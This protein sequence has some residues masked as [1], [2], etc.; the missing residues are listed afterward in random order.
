M[1]A[2][3]MVLPHES[4]D[5]TLT[6]INTSEPYCSE[7]YARTTTEE[8]RVRIRHSKTKATATKP[9]VDR[10]N[11]EVTQIVFATA[12]AV[13]FSRKAYFVFEVPPSDGDVLLM[14][15]LFDWAVATTHANLDKL[16]NWES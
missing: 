15:A 1:F 8:T 9:S 10:H 13:E 7:Y 5:I 12:E 14:D 4:G 6:K 3:T 2:D 11:V 16:A